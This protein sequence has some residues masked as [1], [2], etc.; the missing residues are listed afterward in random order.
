MPKTDDRWC[1]QDGAVSYEPLLYDVLTN[2]DLLQALHDTLPIVEQTMVTHCDKQDPATHL[3]V[4]T[5]Q[6]NGIQVLAQAV[7]DMVDPTLDQGLTDRQ[8]VQTA[9]RNDGTT[10]PQVTPIYLLI[11]A[12]NGIDTAF[13]SWAQAHPMD[14]RQPTWLAARSEIVDE[15][16]S[17]NGTGT[18]STWANPAIPAIVPPLV[19]AVEQQILA[20]CPDRSSRAACTWWTQNM[21]QNLSDT[22]SGPTFAAVMDLIDAIRS[23]TTSRTQ[24]ELLLQY[25]LGASSPSD[26]RAS[27]MTA[28]VDLLQILNDDTNLGPFYHSAADALGAQTLDA[29]GNVTQRGLVD[30]GIEALSRIFAAGYDPQGQELCSEEIDPNQAIAAALQSMVTPMADNQLTPIEVIIDVVAD[31]NRADPALT[32]K[33]DGGDYGNMANEISEFCLDP[34]SGLEQV[35]EVVREATLP[36]QD[37]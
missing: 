29:Q 10:N 6:R 20:E 7:R 15:F 26:A 36:G 4:Q 2:T 27:T 33:L 31:V 23:D 3:C 24:L 19:D 13:A 35:Y 18:Q 21:P 34:A 37:P 17:V 16:F 5:S 12:L 1:S 8:G 11:D 30:G 22:V 25:L 9:P 28:S 32:T 14:D